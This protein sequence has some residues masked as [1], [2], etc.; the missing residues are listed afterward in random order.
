M[1]QQYTSKHNHACTVHML[2]ETLKGKSI[3]TFVHL[4]GRVLAC[5]QGCKQYH[6]VAFS[7]IHL[8]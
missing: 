4:E 3:H 5:Q 6:V 1:D 2:Y 8:F 7:Y